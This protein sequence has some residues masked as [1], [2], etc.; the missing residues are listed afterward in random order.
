MRDRLIVEI[1]E[2]KKNNYEI[3]LHDPKNKPYDSNSTKI[4]NLKSSSIL[5]CIEEIIKKEE[6][7][8]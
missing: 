2:I 1:H 3:I 4:M 8:K 6:I 5:R 7:R